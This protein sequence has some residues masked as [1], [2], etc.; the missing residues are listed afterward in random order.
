MVAETHRA[1][2]M[3]A[4]P[5]R[6]YSATTRL[7]HSDRLGGVEHG[8][9][10]KPLHVSA[11]FNYPTARDLV[12]VFQGNQ[13][14]HVYA[15]QGN[16]TVNALEAKVTLLED[17]KGT[18][19][20]ATGMAVTQAAQKVVEDLKRRAAQLWD[21]PLDTV[22]WI[23]GAAVCLD[24]AAGKGDMSLAALAAEAGQGAAA[25]VLAS[26]RTTLLVLILVSV[27]N[28]ALGVWRPRLTRIPP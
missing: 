21:V 13:A 19:T 12:E 5:K 1:S 15:R 16:P 11:A 24:P 10:H 8:A 2:R 17:A 18:A 22:E 6:A 14:G 23:D 26:E 9:I 28:V 20:F 3:T 27:A 7:L 25:A 4:P